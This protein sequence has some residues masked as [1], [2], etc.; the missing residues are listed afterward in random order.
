MKSCFLLRGR[1]MVARGCPDE[2]RRPDCLHFYR[3]KFDGQNRCIFTV[4]Q[5]LLLRIPCKYAD[6][7]SCGRRSR[8]P[9]IARPVFHSRGL[10][11]C[12]QG[13]LENVL[14]IR[15]GHEDGHQLESLHFYGVPWPHRRGLK[16]SKKVVVKL[17]AFFLKAVCKIQIDRRLESLHFKGAF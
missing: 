1:P 11:G 6:D 4:S 8:Y 5:A 2:G 16:S 17:T 14:Q 9:R 3:V 10:L 13:P 12:S 7:L 15:G